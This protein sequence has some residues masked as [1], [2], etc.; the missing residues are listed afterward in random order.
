VFLLR[1]RKNARCAAIC[2]LF[3]PA[4]GPQRAFSK[5]LFTLVDTRVQPWFA[6]GRAAERVKSNPA[7]FWEQYENGELWG[8]ENKLWDFDFNGA[9]HLVLTG[10]AYRR[11]YERSYDYQTR[12]D[13]DMVD[14][15]I[16]IRCLVFFFGVAGT[17]RLA[18]RRRMF[19]N[20]RDKKDPKTTW[21][22]V[23]VGSKIEVSVRAG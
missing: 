3:P 13:L 14:I 16:P 8:E 9:E 10:D 20:K 18:D 21:V 22:N 1:K 2:L 5:P 7:E 19:T 4:Q 11:Y 17:V 12:P 6:H 23:L 15:V